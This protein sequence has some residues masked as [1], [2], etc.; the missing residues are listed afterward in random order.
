[1]RQP[2]Y[3]D[4]ALRQAVRQSVS[5]R[6]VLSRLNLKPAG[7]NYKIA[8]RRIHVLGLD[9]SH[10]KGQGW[11]RGNSAPPRP[12]TPL[13]ALLICGSKY[14]SHKLKSRLLKACLKEH[15]CDCCGLSEWLEKPI[16]LELHHTNGD[17]TDNRLANIRL[18]CPNCH[19][20]TDNYR[21]KRL[22]RV[23]TRR[24]QPKGEFAHG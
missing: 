2:P 24:E 7:G 6:E 16:P 15:R 18:L 9:T 12:A 3:T 14:Q 21:G 4:D 19:A 5:I 1:M 22:K 20:L 8:H 13:A 23:E 10:F 11:K 17:P